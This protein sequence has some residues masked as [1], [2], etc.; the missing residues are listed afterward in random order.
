MARYVYDKERGCMVHKDTREP[1]V[2]PDEW[3]PTVPRLTLDIQGY[4]SPITGEWIGDKK[5]EREHMKAH[6]VIPAAEIRKPKKLKNQRFIEKHGL[7]G[8]AE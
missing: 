1:M 4:N 7:Q 3:T 8:L 6:D 5:T 2:N